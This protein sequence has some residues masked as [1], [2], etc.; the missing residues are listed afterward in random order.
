MTYRKILIC[1]CSNIKFF[2][3]IFHNIVLK[4]K[5]ISNLANEIGKIKLLIVITRLYSFYLQLMS[6][7]ISNIYRVHV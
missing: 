3:F 1:D 5:Y 7:M 2:A 6:S 4:I